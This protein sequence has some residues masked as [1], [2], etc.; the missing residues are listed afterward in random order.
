MRQ[1][2]QQAATAALHS[3]RLSRLQDT[4]ESGNS[5]LLGHVTALAHREKKP[6]SFRL[7]LGQQHT[8]PNRQLHKDPR[9]KKLYKFRLSLPR[10]FSESVWDF[11]MY[12]SEG[13]WAVYLQHMNIRPS[14]ASIFEVVESGNVE[15]VRQLIQSGRLSFQD[16][17]DKAGHCASLLEVS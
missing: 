15:A 3:E 14:E 5:Q 8:K 12:V 1:H 9:R 17:A 10:W 11:G 6:S 16:C 2:T 7:D 4:L 13:S